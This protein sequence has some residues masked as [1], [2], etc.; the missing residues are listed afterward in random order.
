MGKRVGGVICALLLVALVSGLAQGFEFTDPTALFSTYIPE[1]WVYQAHQSSPLLTVFY[2]EGDF[3]LVYFEQLQPVPDT[4][5]QGLAERTLALYGGAGGLTDFSLQESVQSI[6][7]GG[8]IGASCAYTYE[9]TNGNKL[10][11]YRIFVVLPERRGLSITFG[12]VGPWG[13]QHH[14][15]LEDILSQWRWLF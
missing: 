6:T 2:G 11:E 7:V 4:S 3:D 13:D 12:G 5:A 15:I 8:L 9:D 1:H 10:W 14:P